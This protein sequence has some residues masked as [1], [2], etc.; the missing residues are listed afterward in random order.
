MQQSQKARKVQIRS[1]DD[2]LLRSGMLK[3][4]FVCSLPKTGLACVNRVVT[5]CAQPSCQLGR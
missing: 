5:V 3:Y 4:V 1:D 2:A